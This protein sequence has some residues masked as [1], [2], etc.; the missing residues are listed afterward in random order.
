[1]RNLIKF[2]WTIALLFL[3]FTAKSQVNHRMKI[4]SYNIWNGFEHTKAKADKFVHWIG[5]Q[6]P[7]IVALEEL[8]D[9]KEADLQQ[10]ARSYGHHYSI[11]LKEKGYPVG[12]TSR[13]PITLIKAQEGEFWHGM[14]HVKIKDIDIIVTHLSP[15]SWKYRLKEAQQIVDYI[16]NNHLDNCMI[17]GDLNAYS[18]LDAIWLERKD[19][20]RKNLLNWDLAHPE[21]GNMR[22]QRFDY[23]VLSTFM[24]AGFDD[25]IGRMVFPE[26]KRVSFPTATLYGWNWGD[27]RITAVAE[28]LDYI[29]LSE[30][31]SPLAKEVEVHNGPDLEGISDHYPVSVVIGQLEK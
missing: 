21:Y 1:M 15:F 31:L 30:S 11:L 14:L 25:C 8:V 2:Y 10:L 4:I 12:I 29:L 26:N 28:R 17:M 7:D 5:Q 18:P 27:S 6:Q 22:G 24:A 3:C 23:S 19:H 16:K 20:L 9:F 13:Y